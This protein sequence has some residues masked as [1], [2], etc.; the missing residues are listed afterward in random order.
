M[1]KEVNRIDWKVAVCYLG[2][3]WVVGLT[4]ENG[5]IEAAIWTLLTYS[6]YAKA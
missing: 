6:P 5:W 1:K 4:Y 3:L 2:L